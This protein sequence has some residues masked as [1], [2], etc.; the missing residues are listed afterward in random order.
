MPVPS[1]SIRSQSTTSGSF[2]ATAAR[3]SATEAAD[4][5]LHPSSSK[6]MVRKSRRDA[7]SST[8]RRSTQRL[9]FAAAQQT[10][11][12][13]A[14]TPLQPFGN[15]GT[16]RDQRDYCGA[17]RHA[18]AERRRRPL[19]LVT[20]AQNALPH[21]V[22]AGDD[23]HDPPALRNEIEGA[24][25]LALLTDAMRT[26]IPLIELHRTPWQVVVHDDRR[27]LQIETFTREI[28]RNEPVA[29]APPECIDRTPAIA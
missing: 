3:P 8:M 26:S 12:P 20:P 23:A 15:I 2:R 1:G 6:T 14:M 21:A 18:R 24:H 19:P 25:L 16:I 22:L 4:S 5:T 29:P 28:R 27:P 17:V 11:Q 10:F 7:S 13:G 9:Y